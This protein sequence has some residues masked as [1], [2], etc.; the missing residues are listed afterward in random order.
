L[1]LKGLRRFN[2]SGDTVRGLQEAGLCFCAETKTQL[3]LT[4]LPLRGW[5]LQWLGQGVI[6]SWP[7]AIYE[8]ITEMF[9]SSVE[10]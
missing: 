5:A 8:F 3:R 2:R 1:G 7:Q 10:K 6:T 9:A 4:D